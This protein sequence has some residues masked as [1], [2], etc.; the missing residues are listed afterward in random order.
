MSEVVAVRE[1]RMVVQIVEELSKK[2]RVILYI[3]CNKL[4]CLGFFSE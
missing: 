4:K 2:Q 3:C 1:G